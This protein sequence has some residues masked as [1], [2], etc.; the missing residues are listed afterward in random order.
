[1][2]FIANNSL[3]RLFAVPFSSQQVY[4]MPTNENHIYVGKQINAEKLSKFCY[5]FMRRN[6]AMIKLYLNNAQNYGSI[7]RWCV[8]ILFVI[9]LK[10]VVW[11]YKTCHI[12][13]NYFVIIKISFC[14]SDFENKVAEIFM[15]FHWT[16]KCVWKIALFIVYIRKRP[17]NGWQKYAGRLWFL[18][19]EIK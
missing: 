1:M 7:L 15:I 8:T 9:I 13:K 2:L 18:M 10:R 16:S 4:D 17:V 5:F 19:L 14:E 3:W 12:K 6:F 11:S